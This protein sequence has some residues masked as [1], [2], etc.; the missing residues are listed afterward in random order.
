MHY[1]KDN[2]IAY[3]ERCAVHAMS[4]FFLTILSFVQFVRG[5]ILKSYCMREPRYLGCKA[6]PNPRLA[7]T[8][9]LHFSTPIFQ[10]PNTG[11]R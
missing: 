11:Q 9:H 8:K 7:S 6:F 2:S 3:L 10:R 4:L 1:K 5:G